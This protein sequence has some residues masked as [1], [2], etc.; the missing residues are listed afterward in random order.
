[1]STSKEK[2]S[3]LWAQKIFD[4]LSS[5]NCPCFE[6]R[7][8]FDALS[9][10]DFSMLWAQ[11]FSCKLRL[12]DRRVFG[13]HFSGVEN[14]E[15]RWFTIYDGVTVCVCHCV[16]VSLC[17]FVTVCVWQDDL[18]MMASMCVCDVLLI[19]WWVAKFCFWF[20]SSKY[21][22]HSFFKHSFSS[23]KWF[24]WQ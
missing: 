22:F 4:A 24:F 20:F 5:E 12:I 10:E 18:Y 3:M 21:H 8:F 7:N 9:S 23:R 11:T 17:V 19:W 14:P 2:I 16:C 13:E 1:M 6:L 15:T